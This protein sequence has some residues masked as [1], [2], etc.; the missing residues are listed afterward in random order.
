M[1]TQQPAQAA[2]SEESIMIKPFA[3]SASPMPESCANAR[4]PSLATISMKARTN[5]GIGRRFASLVVYG[6]GKFDQ[7]WAA[8]VVVLFFVTAVIAASVPSLRAR[9]AQPTLLLRHG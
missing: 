4:G 7:R 5:G 9:H 8:F 3:A 2:N 1:V 6:A